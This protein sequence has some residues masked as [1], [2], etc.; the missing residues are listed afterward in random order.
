[1]PFSQPNNTPQLI[2]IN[3][4]HKRDD[5][6]ST[7]A[8]KSFRSALCFSLDVMCCAE[9]NLIEKLEVL[10]TQIW[11]LS[12]KLNYVLEQ[13][14]VCEHCFSAKMQLWGIALLKATSSLLPAVSEPADGVIALVMTSKLRSFFTFSCTWYPSPCLS[15]C[16]DKSI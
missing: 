5:G 14:M 16:S 6:I 10:C 11:V 4:W 8:L 9:F 7:A 2:L 1:M 15:G 13:H 12:D 3:C